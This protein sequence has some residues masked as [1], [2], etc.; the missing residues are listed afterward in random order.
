MKKALIAITGVVV[1]VAATLLAVPLLA[2]T[3]AVSGRIAAA[4]RSATGRELGITGGIAMR[5]LPTP[6]FTAA[7]ITFGNAPWGAVPAMAQI[8]SIEVNLRLLALLGG[9]IEVASLVLIEPDIALEIGPD[10]RGNWMFTPPS[11]PAAPPG[12]PAATTASPTAISLADVRIEGGRGSLRDRRAGTEQHLDNISLQLALPALD[13]TATAAGTAT[14]NGE[15]TR[16]T[17]SAS[18]PGA[19]LA[20]G[21]GAVDLRIEAAPLRLAFNGR[22]QGMPPKRTEGAIDIASPS[23]RRLASWTGGKFALPGSEPGALAIKG[24]LL[25]AGAE[26]QFSEASIALDAI[27]STGN[28]TVNIAAARPRLTGSLVAGVLDLNPYL[29]DAKPAPP[30]KPATPQPAAPDEAGWSDAPIDL[31]ALGIAD[32]TLD[33]AAEQIL[34]RKLRIERPRLALQLQEGKLHADLREIALYRGQ[35]KAVLTLDSQTNPPALGLTLALAGTDIDG[36]LSAAIGFERLA[37]VGRFDLAITSRGASQRAL[38]AALTGNGAIDLTDGRIRG[39]DLLS[40]ARK[41]IPGGGGGTASNGTAFGSFTASFTIA[42]GILDNEDLQLRSGPIPVVGAGHVDLPS[43][44]IDYRLVAQI[45]GALKIPVNVTG[46]WDH[47]TYQPDL[48]KT[49]LPTNLLRGL[50]PRP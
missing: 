23:L 3:D 26:M 45:A 7:G 28:L 20:G 40:I 21:E 36:L 13:Q 44:T 8:K 32:V 4:V 2:P 17:L 19:L 46:H 31:A 39:V 49:P 43:R 27:R 24:R 10:G 30:A 14:W 12:A 18:A 38:I 6:R 9:R 11:R 15:E 50:L 34:Y 29:P 16:I 33:L 25:A 48:P 47:I 42:N 1:L 22:L 41:A 37:G 35:G 5:L